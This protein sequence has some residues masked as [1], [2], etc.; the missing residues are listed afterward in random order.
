ITRFVVDAGG[1]PHHELR[2]DHLNTRAIGPGTRE[3]LLAGLAPMAPNLDALFIS[4]YDE[5]VPP[6][7]IFRDGSFRRAMIELV[8]QNGRK[9]PRA[10]RLFGS[11]RLHVAELAGLD[12]VICND[13]EAARL[14]DDERKQLLETALCVT[15]G[16]DGAM[17]L[18]GGESITV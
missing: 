11:S 3:R 9:A 7:G 8:R 17:H 16:K 18:E 5:T 6:T 4:D 13:A 1:T 14:A 15:L 10:T 2:L 12:C